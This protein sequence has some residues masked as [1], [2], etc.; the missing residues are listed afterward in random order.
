M[1]G[2]LAKWVVALRLE[3]NNLILILLIIFCLEPTKQSDLS[4]QIRM[5]VFIVRLVGRVRLKYLTRL[6]LI[7]TLIVRVEL[8]TLKVI[9]NSAPMIYIQHWLVPT[10]M[11]DRTLQRLF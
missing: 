2:D 4:G 10:D 6:R 3:L 8:L 11:I 5:E 1:R 7:G 9:P